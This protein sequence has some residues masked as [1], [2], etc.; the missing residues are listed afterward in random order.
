MRNVLITIL[1]SLA[2]MVSKAQEVSITVDATADTLYYDNVM[3]IK[4]TI[5]NSQG[6]F[7][8]P[9]LEGWAIASGPNTSSQMS[10]I[11]GR[12]SSLSSYE[13]IISPLQEGELVIG[14]AYLETSEGTLETNP[15][16]V[17]IKSNPD[18]IRQPM[19]GYG[20]SQELI[21]P[22]EQKKMTKQDSLRMK[23]RRLKSVKK[24]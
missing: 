23:L 13:Y 16:S 19:R 11:N 12:V 2:M 6:D 1:A 4:F 24:I 20:F 22:K 9:S 18:G 10:I 5:E 21:L 15:L 8:P 3:S 17:F 14:S 7:Q